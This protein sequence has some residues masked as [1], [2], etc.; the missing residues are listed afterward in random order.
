[1]ELARTIDNGLYSRKAFSATRE[2]FCSFCSMAARP[3][4]DGLVTVT[5]TV[6]SQ[7]GG[8]ARRIVLECWNYFLDASAKH[9]LE[10]E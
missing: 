3:R 2:A 1:M 7:H 4:D 8:D 5:V 6:R 9:R 10:E